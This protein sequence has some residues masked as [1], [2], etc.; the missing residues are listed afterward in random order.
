MF[1][2]SVE[3]S[4]R[5]PFTIDPM[6]IKRD[7]MDQ[8]SEKH[9]YRCFPVTQANVIGWSISCS[10]DIVFSWDGINDQTDQ[11]VKIDSP[12]G[13]YSGRGQSSISLNTGLTFKTDQDVSILTINPVNYFSNDFETMSNL[14]STSFYGNPLPLAIKAKKA[15]ETVVIKAGTPIATL[16]PISLTQLNNTIINIVD[17]KDEDRKR[18]EANR[19]YGEAAQVVNSSGQWTDWYRDAVNEK[20]DSLG[21]HE[22]K[23]LRLYVEDTTS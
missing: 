1:N 4:H 5:S 16:I 8:T 15:N 23:T 7:W 18:A 17:Y 21:S 2:I 6:S 12:E 3:K 13:S 9:A 10:E 22:T 20:G 14:I 11:H 19:S